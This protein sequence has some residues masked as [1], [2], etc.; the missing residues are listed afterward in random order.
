M[1]EINQK[2]SNKRLSYLFQYLFQLKKIDQQDGYKMLNY[3]F[4]QSAS[5]E[6]I[7]DLA[8][9]LNRIGPESSSSEYKMLFMT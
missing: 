7:D 2:D 8:F 9:E 1:E 6:K 4:E 5:N 3:L